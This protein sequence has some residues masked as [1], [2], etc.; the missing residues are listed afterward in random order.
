MAKLSWKERFVKATQFGAK[1][2]ISMYA[3]LGTLVMNDV[4]PSNAIEMLYGRYLKRKDVKAGMLK[5]WLYGMRQGHGIASVMADWITPG[6]LMM[7]EAAE[8]SGKLGE[9]LKETERMLEAISRIKSMARTKSAI[10]VL[11]LITI[12][13]ALVGLS[14]NLIPVFREIDYPRE[15]WESGVLFADWVYRV[16][17]QHLFFVILALV[18]FVSLIMYSLPNLAHPIRYKFLDKLPPYNIYRAFQGS[19]VMVALS[20]MLGSGVPVDTALRKIQGLSNKYIRVQIELVLQRLRSGSH[21][22]DA[23]QIDLFDDDTK[24]DIF[25]YSQFGDFDTAMRRMS[26]NSIAQAEQAVSKA[27]GSA[28]KL[29]GAGGALAMLWIMYSVVFTL[30]SLTDSLSF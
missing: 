23:L 30:L 2:R 24:D 19:A 27:V 16:V 25:I 1:E 26:N 11:V 10:P 3:R 14:M 17:Y 13:A 7:L 15:N 5:K 4:G 28:N 9:S 29:V 21:P 18:G 20:T 12:M 6:E 8:S 22:K